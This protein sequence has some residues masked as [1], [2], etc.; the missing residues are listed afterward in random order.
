MQITMIV[1]DVAAKL[2]GTTR[3]YFVRQAWCHPLCDHAC[4]RHR[5]KLA[6]LTCVNKEEN[7]T[8]SAKILLPS[9]QDSAQQHKY[10]TF[11]MKIK[12][13]G[14]RTTIQYFMEPCLTGH[15]KSTSDAPV[16]GTTTS[17]AT[18]FTSSPATLVSFYKGTS[19]YAARLLHH[20]P[21]FPVGPATQP[22]KWVPLQLMLKIALGRTS[23]TNIYR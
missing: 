19:S 1:L 4:H 9:N 12:I 7:S 8:C 11:Y 6:Q 22:K 20:N 14:C 21:T 10:H 16:Y 13:L 5:K 3:D 23:S 15:T 2:L 18:T 17:A